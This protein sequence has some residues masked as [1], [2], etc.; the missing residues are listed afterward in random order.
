MAEMIFPTALF[1]TLFSLHIA[2]V[3]LAVCT[4]ARLHKQADPDVTNSGALFAIAVALGYVFDLLLVSALA[5]LDAL[6]LASVT[7]ALL[8]SSAASLVLLFRQKTGSVFRIPRPERFAL[9]LLLVV[10]LARAL[11]P[12]GH[13]DDTMYHLPLARLIAE[14][15]GLIV[16]PYIRFPL[17][18]QTM[19]AMYAMAHMT[20]G[21]SA[22]QFVAGVPL[23]LSAIGLLSVSRILFGSLAPGVIAA[24]ALP[25]FSFVSALFGVAYVDLALGFCCSYALFAVVIADRTSSRL[26]LVIA[27]IFTGAACGIKYMALPFALLLAIYLAA[28]RRSPSDLYAFA[29]TA[30][31]VGGAWYLRSW[32]ISGDPFHPIL[33]NLVGHYLWD[34]GDL[35]AQAAEQRTLSDGRS[36]TLAL[37]L[38]PKFFAFVILIGVVAAV[39]RKRRPEL[40]GVCLLVLASCCL[41]LVTT[42][43]DRYLL[44]VIPAAVLMIGAA[45]VH[46]GEQ[47][48]A[49]VGLNARAPARERLLEIGTTI[50]VGMV[51]LFSGWQAYGKL[52]HRDDLLRAIPGYAAFNRADQLRPVLGNRLFQIGFGNAKYFFGGQAIGDHFGPG[53]YR[54][55]LSCPARR[56]RCQVAGP[57]WMEQFLG[58]LGASMLIIDTRK[59]AVDEAAYASA[60]DIVYRGTDGSILMAPKSSDWKK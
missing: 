39:S 1:A 32:I 28:R 4:A 46:V 13:F 54:P 41:W 16:A 53:R 36:G 34:S 3:G 44:P 25:T 58:G 6:S 15:Q 14:H 23:V 47:V 50:C 40:T 12:P 57:E 7:A 29:G 52:K 56:P 48:L 18:P 8:V 51:A 27:G 17:F 59:F 26:W 60:F 22:A 21:V 49:R 11:G 33:G 20:A 24:L 31:L 5:F 35:A 10:A 2:V 37:I 19:E 55:I 30:L 38:R 45:A 43:V 42:K 9:P